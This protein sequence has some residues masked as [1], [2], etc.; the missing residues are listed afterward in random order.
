MKNLLALL[1]PLLFTP[2]AFAQS[3]TKAQ[4]IGSA[5]DNYGKVAGAWYL[6]GKCKFLDDIKAKEF[7]QHVATITV[8]LNAD[9]GG[10]KKS[11]PRKRNNR[12]AAAILFKVLYR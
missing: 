12:R 4:L 5:L 8:A 11:R 3:P 2:S 10:P 9:L 7:E 1:I 6:N